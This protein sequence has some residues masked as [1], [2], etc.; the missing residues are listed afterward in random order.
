M[1]EAS[2]CAYCRARWRLAEVDLPPVEHTVEI[3][4]LSRKAVM[5]QAK[6]LFGAANVPPTL[7]GHGLAP[8]VSHEH[9][10]F[11][12][13]DADRDGHIDHVTA[14]LKRGF[15]NSTLR[16]MVSLERLYAGSW[17][18]WPV[19]EHWI[20]GPG[21][22]LGSLVGRSRVWTSV[23]PFLSPRH[24][25][26]RHSETDE[27]HR[28]CREMGLPEPETITPIPGPEVDGRRL[29]SSDFRWKRL[30]QYNVT[31]DKRG[32]FFRLQ[33]AEPLPGPLALGYN[34]HFGLGLFRPGE[35]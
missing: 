17:G 29:A 16:A 11:L 1:N 23:T 20:V 10:F 8:D 7:S 14:F 25:K 22:P 6:N 21:E 18:E 30:R 24:L 31:P 3:G 33:F 9:I 35:P 2:T 19:I 5:S 12:P 27:I 28:L 4:D 15:D 13:E 32:G 26:S 34:C